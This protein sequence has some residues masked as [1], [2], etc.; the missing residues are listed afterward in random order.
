MLATFATERTEGLLADG[1]PA[2]EA[3]NSGYHLAYLIGAGLVMAGIPIAIGFLRGA[4]AR[5]SGSPNRG[6]A[7][8]EPALAVAPRPITA[9]PLPAGAVRDGCEETGLGVEIGCG[10]GTGSAP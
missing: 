4:R 10:G 2:A 3:L 7:L 1:E 5:G 9:R 8:V 6:R